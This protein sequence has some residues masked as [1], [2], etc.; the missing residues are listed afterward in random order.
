M[1]KAISI[2]EATNEY[3]IVKIPR[4]EYEGLF[5]KQEDK[6]PEVKLTPSEKRAIMQSEK[7]LKRGD[8]ITLDELEYELGR[9]RA[10]A[11]K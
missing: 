11:R 5:R 9:S 2:L 1:V 3:I 10:K 8:Y 4:K 7:E 6:F